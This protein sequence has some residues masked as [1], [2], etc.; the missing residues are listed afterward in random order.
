MYFVKSIEPKKCNLN[1]EKTAKHY[2]YIGQD[3]K[4]YVDL[5]NF[6]EHEDFQ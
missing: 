1:I 6:S 4:Q 2:G 5:L 3:L